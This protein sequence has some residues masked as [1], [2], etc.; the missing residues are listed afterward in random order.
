MK[1]R[2]IDS[3]FVD[4]FTVSRYIAKHKIIND[5]RVGEFVLYSAPTVN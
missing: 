4:L 1:R 2:K 5:E 3:L